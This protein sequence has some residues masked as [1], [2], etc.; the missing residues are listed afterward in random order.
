M[1]QLQVALQRADSEALAR[2][3]AEETVAE[4][5][6][7]KTVKELEINDVL[8]RHSNDINTKDNIISTLKEKEEEL[9]GEVESYKARTDEMNN[10]L[11]IAEAERKKALEESQEDVEKL[12]K[13]LKSE[14]VLKMQAVNKL[15]EILQRKENLPANRKGKPISSDLRKKEK[16]CRKLQQELTMEREKFSQLEMKRQKDF[17]DI[18]ASLCEESQSKMRLQMELDAKD[19]EIE[20]LQSRLA[21][22]SSETVSIGSITE[23]DFDEGDMR[24][25]GWLS[26]PNKQNI[27][28]HGWKKQYVVVSSRKIFFYNS[29]SDKQNSDPILI[30]D[31]SKLFHV[32]P[33]TQGDVIRAEARDIPRIFQILYAGEGESRKPGQ[34]DSSYDTLPTEKP[35]SLLHKGHEFLAITF[36]IPTNCEVCA[37]HLWAMF[38]PPPALECRRCRMKVHKEHL[39]KMEEVISPC[40]IS[41]DLNTAKEMLLLASTAEEQ[42]HWVLKL[43]KKIKKSGYKANQSVH[44]DGAKVS[45]RESTSSYK[46][47][48][49]QKSSTLPPNSNLPRK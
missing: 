18:Q 1:E 5:E 27:K 16:E 7:E 23:N 33:V 30:L 28:R 42:Q 24:L 41:N 48:L 46:M 8:S 35:A 38:K 36:H 10:K 40:K 22:I 20:Q 9:I 3:V 13:Q 19:S 43:S 25:E 17:Q 34:E 45:P 29:E 12:T 47:F 31:L 32:R 39:D 49:P 14:Q 26:R 37:K 6:K 2:S 11:K 44:S 21:N 4:L 15:A